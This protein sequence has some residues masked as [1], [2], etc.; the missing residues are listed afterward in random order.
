[1][2]LLSL[3]GTLGVGRAAAARVPEFALFP[4]RV[5]R[6]AESLRAAYERANTFRAAFRQSHA[7]RR[8]NTGWLTFRRPGQFAFRYDNGNRVVSDGELVTVYDKKNNRMFEQLVETSQYPAVLSFLL[9]QASLEQWF[10]LTELDPK[11]FLFRGGWVLQARPREASPAYRKMLLYIDSAT[12]EVRRVLLL[13]E[14][15]NRNR[16]DFSRARLN[17]PIQ[18]REFVLVPSSGVA[19][20]R[21]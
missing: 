5:D 10:E 12:Y 19:V 1:V 16:F 3:G 15:G 7:G 4:N 2:T 6:I 18:A 14:Q 11:R 9:R 13:D 17:H 8:G 21:L 20:I